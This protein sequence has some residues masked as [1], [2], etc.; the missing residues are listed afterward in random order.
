MNPPLPNMVPRSG[1]PKRLKS[2]RIFVDPP[3]VAVALAWVE[4]LI[5]PWRTLLQVRYPPGDLT[6]ENGQAH[7]AFLQRFPQVAG[8][9]PFCLPGT[10]R[11]A[12]LAPFTTPEACGTCIFREGRACPGLRGEGYADAETPLRALDRP[13]GAYGAADFIADPPAA[14]WQ[15]TEAHLRALTDALRGRR[16]W[17]IG[18]A[19]GYLAARLAERGIDVTVVDPVAWPTP[20]GVQRVV[21][22]VRVFLRE[23]PT[24]PDALITSWPPTGDG[25]RDVIEALA[26][27]V[28]V[29]AGD[30]DGF[31]GCHPGH[32]AVV[33]TAR[34][35]AW[36]GWPQGDGRW[37]GLRLRHTWRVH[38][39]HD[40][41]TTRAPQGILRLYARPP[42]AV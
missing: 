39:P 42:E 6:P 29:T 32:A 11:H 40:L 14:W 41:R 17:D 2:L 16:V 21:A 24:L 4:P 22:D 1:P 25:F 28:L 30:A 9:L 26:P 31:C 36:F 15:P 27:A 34:G 19:N 18:G 10:P 23:S 35:L 7:A 12:E 5:G 37:P 33:A 38:T 8:Y 3:D 20:P 13:A